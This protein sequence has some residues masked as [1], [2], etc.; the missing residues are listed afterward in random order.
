MYIYITSWLFIRCLVAI[1]DGVV[2]LWA[3]SAVSTS[4]ILPQVQIEAGQ[5]AAGD[6]LVVTPQFGAVH[7]VKGPRAR[8]ISKSTMVKSNDPLYRFSKM[9]FTLKS[10]V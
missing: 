2:G 4:G 10:L 5:G 9:R 6:A 7:E 1:L 3:A 8:H